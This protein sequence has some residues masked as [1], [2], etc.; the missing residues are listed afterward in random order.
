[1]ASR[2]PRRFGRYLLAH[3]LLD[4]RIAR[5]DRPVAAEDR[6]GAAVLQRDRLKEVL[7]ITDGDRRRDDAEKLAVRAA[8]TTREIERPDAGRPR[9]HRGADEK[10]RVLMI[11]KMDVEIPVRYIDL[12]DR[13]A[14]RVIRD[15][16][17][18]SDDRE[19][20][21]LGQAFQL[22]AQKTID[23]LAGRGLPELR[24]VAN[25]AVDEL[26]AHLLDDESDRLHRARGLFRDDDA[27]IAD[28]APIISDRIA[29]EIGDRQARGADDGHDQGSAN[30]R[31]IAAGPKNPPL[32][33]S[34]LHLGPQR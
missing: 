18:R 10:P 34:G 11:A 13:P 17:V 12:G 33:G 4:M 8:D 6:D 14:A 5:Q 30:E 2:K 28:V 25:A 27:E 19:G 24:R 22:I 9:L 3:L 20:I 1:M 31:E 7:E 29:A 15:P 16:S 32:A 26:V 21:G 23:V